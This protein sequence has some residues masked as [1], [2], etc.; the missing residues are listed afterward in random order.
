MRSL[1]DGHKFKGFPAGV[2]IAIVLIVV[3]KG[4]QVG[5][6][7]MGGGDLA[8]QMTGHLIAGHT[9]QIL[10]RFRDISPEG[11]TLDL[12]IQEVNGIADQ[13]ESVVEALVPDALSSKGTTFE[14][15]TWA[16]TC[17]IPNGK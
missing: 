5:Q 7:F 10:L 8:N 9:V 1:V 6:F 3:A 16:R 17:G 14:I 12:H 2:L 15:I 4:Y 11:R 13:R